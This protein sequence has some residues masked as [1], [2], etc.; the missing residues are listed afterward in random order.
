MCS[1]T[2]NLRP[3]AQ[4]KGTRGYP[5]PTPGRLGWNAQNVARNNFHSQGRG[6]KTK[7]CQVTLLLYLDSWLSLSLSQFFAVQTLSFVL[8]LLQKV[9]VP[10]YFFPL[11][12]LLPCS[13]LSFL[14]EVHFSRSEEKSCRVKKNI[15]IY[16]THSFFP[17]SYYFMDQRYLC[18]MTESVLPT[19]LKIAWCRFEVQ[20]W[21]KCK[22]ISEDRKIFLEENIWR[23][24]VF[25]KCKCS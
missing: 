19:R 21:R 17:T 20:F 11:S 10:S 3:Q 7:Y 15:C 6:R 13:G 4:E 14:R 16:F 18:K 25:V 24:N 9:S 12:Q 2:Q 23:K 22:K 5:R 1:F 8:S